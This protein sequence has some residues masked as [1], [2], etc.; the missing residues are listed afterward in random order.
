MLLADVVTT[1]AAVGATRSR[2]AKARALADLVAAAS[3]AEVG[4]VAAWLAGETMQGR[5]GIGRRRLS[6]GRA[7]PADGP[8]LTVLEVDAALARLATTTGPG[9]EA[10]RD[11]LLAG[12][13]G[14]ATADEQAFLVRLLTGELRQGALEGVMLDAVATAAAVAPA[15]LRRAFMLSGS[16]PGVAATALQGG[17]DALAAVRLEV[18]R[19][20]RPMLASPGS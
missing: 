13:L 8:G 16:L 11:A 15:A 5:V 1:S 7:E 12:L 14:A 6:A 17:E 18:G 3:P 10:R 20:L 2:T 4:P 9:S 19:P